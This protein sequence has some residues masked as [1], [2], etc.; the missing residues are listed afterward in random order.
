MI[1]DRYEH[2]HD[3]AEEGGIEVVEFR[4]ER[5]RKVLKE[6]LAALAAADDAKKKTR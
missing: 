4:V 2:L 5:H 1:E 6:R 3:R